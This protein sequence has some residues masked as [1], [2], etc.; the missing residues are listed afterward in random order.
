M[1]TGRSS[2]QFRLASACLL[3]LAV[4]LSHPTISAEALLLAAGAASKEK[5]APQEQ[6]KDDAVGG[7]DASR[8]NFAIGKHYDA[9]TGEHARIAA[10]AVVVKE[11]EQ[12][13]PDTLE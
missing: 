2:G 5:S 4:T 12:G 13:T 7:C 9:A 1:R 3:L 6:Q 10:G 11:Y 8:A